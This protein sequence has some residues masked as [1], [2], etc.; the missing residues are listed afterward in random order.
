MSLKYILPIGAH[1]IDKAK[2][3]IEVRFTVDGD[4]FI[5]FGME[6][7]ETVEPGEL[8]YTSG[9]NVKTR[10]WIWRQSEQGKI[11]EKSVNIFFPID[12][13][14]NV[15]HEAVIAARD[16]LA[17]TLRNLFNCQVKV[18]YVDKNNKSMLLD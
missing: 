4:K 12:G 11:T 2:D 18:G 8:I 15:N 1:D 9:N 13:F 14:I 17:Q 16:E 5:P 3:G 7:P 6:E 10:R